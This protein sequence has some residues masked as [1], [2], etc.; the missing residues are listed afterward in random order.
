MTPEERIAEL[1]KAM[2]KMADH[3]WRFQGRLNA[4][5]LAALVGVHNLAKTQA[6]P[7]EWVQAYVEA[8][9]QTGR[10]LIP[11]VDSQ[12]DGARLLKETKNGIDEFLEQVVAHAGNLPGAPAHKK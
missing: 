12:S 9:R 10:T 11:D 1:E 6:N 3:Y 5:E 8:M 2:H 7:F 4:L